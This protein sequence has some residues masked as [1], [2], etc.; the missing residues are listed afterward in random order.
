VIF[1]QTEF[2]VCLLTGLQELW[3]RQFVWEF[4][5]SRVHLQSSFVQTGAKPWRQI[6]LW[7]SLCW[8]VPM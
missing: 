5:S 6:C 2:N 3:Q 7:I 8:Q 4:L 1:D